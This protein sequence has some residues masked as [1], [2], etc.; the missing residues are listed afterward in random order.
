MS[1]KSEEL[2]VD[3]FSQGGFSDMSDIWVFWSGDRSKH[4]LLGEAI[5]L[6]A[7]FQWD[8]LVYT[9]THPPTRPSTPP[10]ES[11]ILCKFFTVKSVYSVQLAHYSHTRRR[12]FF[13]FRMRLSSDLFRIFMWPVGFSVVFWNC[14]GIKINICVS[15]QSLF[16]QK[17]NNCVCVY[18]YVCSCGF[19]ACA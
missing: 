11:R 15:F 12:V 13:S 4:S 1:G 18:V 17:N 2:T 16:R 6:P 10:L 9:P 3:A 5:G 7:S 19:C 14:W 8:G